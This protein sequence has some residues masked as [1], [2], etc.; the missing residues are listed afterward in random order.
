M[1]RLLTYTPTLFV[2]LLI[3]YLS[4]LRHPH[5][6][7]PVFAYSDKLAHAAFYILLAGCFTFN[8]FQD[9]GKGWTCTWL[10]IAVVTA[11]GGIIELL[12]EYCFSPR[13]GEWADWGADFLGACIGTL[14]ARMIWNY[15]KRNSTT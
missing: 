5:L 2:A 1:R 11:Y 14:I 12:Q 3:L 10:V 6:S 4:L 7:M 8:R 13:T 15:R 9:K